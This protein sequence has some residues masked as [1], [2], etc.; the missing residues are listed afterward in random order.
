M[1]NPGARYVDRQTCNRYYANPAGM[2]QPVSYTNGAE[3]YGYDL[4]VDRELTAA[5]MDKWTNLMNT[6]WI[7]PAPYARVAVIRAGYHAAGWGGT[8]VESAGIALADQYEGGAATARTELWRQCYWVSGAGA[9]IASSWQIS[10]NSKPVRLVLQANFLK[11][12]GI[13]SLPAGFVY[14]V[15]KGTTTYLRVSLHELKG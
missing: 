11:N 5:H 9:E 4:A 13:G 1:P 7:P 2:W 3:L 12:P 10:A 6:A 15:A 14:R 8:V